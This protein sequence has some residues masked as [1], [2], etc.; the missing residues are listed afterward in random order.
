[1]CAFSG[2]G[3]APRYAVVLDEARS[4]ATATA[5]LR[6]ARS[7]PLAVG[8]PFVAS[9][10]DLSA[11]DASKAH[12]VAVVAGLF[13]LEED[14]RREADRYAGNVVT[15][16]GPIDDKPIDDKPDRVTA[17]EVSEHATAV[18]PRDLALIDGSGPTDIAERIAWWTDRADT[19]PLCH[20]DAGAV[21]IFS[22]EKA[23]ERSRAWAPVRC[24][25]GE[26][27]WVLKRATRWESVVQA[28]AD[29]PMITQIVALQCALA[30]ETRPFVTPAPKELGKL[31]VDDCD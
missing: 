10:D 29:G 20:V 15:L 31:T 12:A 16:T 8:Y 3:L 9:Y 26:L 23:Y 14:A 18:S 25:R 30:L 6:R 2:C 13:A 22:L 21:F 5:A 11:V 7:L 24:P 17:I 28:R 27:G 1:V 19:K 4:D